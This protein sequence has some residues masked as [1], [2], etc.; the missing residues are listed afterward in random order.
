MSDKAESPASAKLHRGLSA[1]IPVEDAKGIRDEADGGVEDN[2]TDGSAP[3]A[4]GISGVIGETGV[5]GS[6]E[7]EDR[8]HSLSKGKTR[9]T[10]Q[11]E[12]VEA[13]NEVRDE[14]TPID[15]K[16]LEKLLETFQSQID[17]QQ[18][19]LD[20]LRE[21]R[22]E[23]SIP[24]KSTELLPTG[25][26]EAEIE[27]AIKRMN[28]RGPDR[29]GWDTLGRDVVGDCLS[30]NSL[31]FSRGSVLADNADFISAYGQNVI[32]GSAASNSGP[33]G[34]STLMERL[35]HR[36]PANLSSQN[37]NELVWS[38]GLAIWRWYMYSG[39]ERIPWQHVCKF[40]RSL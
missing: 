17:L 33:T 7:G 4:T 39:Y 6:P 2:N 15:G 36:W 28:A 40:Q 11:S 38:R 35:K 12:A 8:N 14:R 23:L 21:L 18:R 34:Q 9:G 26:N 30:W 22:T 20:L 32:K 13:V 24:E 1:D 3:G 31:W 16:K 19:Q 27:F 37:E 5:E 10:D 25:P 29:G